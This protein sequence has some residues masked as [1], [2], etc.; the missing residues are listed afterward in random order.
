M[1]VGKLAPIPLYPAGV[2]GAR[3]NG[4]EDR[5]AITPYL[6]ELADGP[7]AAIVV[8]P[9]GGYSYRSDHE[10]GPVCEWLAGLGLAAILL[11]YR[12]KPYRH[13]HPLMDAQ[14]GI[15]LTRSRA[16]EWGI[17]PGRVGILGFS[18]G[19]HLAVSAATCPGDVPPPIGDDVDAQPARP[20]ALIACYPVVTFGEHRHEGS[21]RA[22][23]GDE[24]DGQ[25]RR[26]LSLEHRVTG[27]TPPTF[28]WHTAEDGAVPV[29]NALLLAEALSQAGVRFALHVYPRGRHGLG[30]V[31]DPNVCGQWTAACEHWLDEEGFTPGV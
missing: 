13:P 23:L 19:G 18:A 22:L 24:P 7:T 25:L 26:E 4:P 30:I 27:E 29:E 15:R 8:C 14:R 20:D 10:G 1:A 21:M 5:P 16:G 9:G 12:V 31:H 3:G 11:D 28:I 6:P 2:P 17:D